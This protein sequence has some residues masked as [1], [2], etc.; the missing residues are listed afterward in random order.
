MVEGSGLK[1]RIGPLR[2][3][4]VVEHLHGQAWLDDAVR[5]LALYRD[6]LVIPGL[7]V[8]HERRVSAGDGYDHDASASLEVVEGECL[9]FPLHPTTGHL[10]DE[11]GG[12]RLEVPDPEHILAPIPR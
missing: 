10:P 1:A 5:E 3:D 8:E 2:V 4:H 9:P 7:L 6:R 12:L 11:L